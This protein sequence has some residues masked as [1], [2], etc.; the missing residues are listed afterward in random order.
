MRKTLLLL[1][2][3]TLALL[4]AGGVALAATKQCQVG[5]VCNGTSSADTITGTNSN[6]TINGLAGNDSISARDG[7]DKI[8][9]GPNNDTMDGGASNDTYKFADNWG[10]DRISADSAG[11]DT[12]NFAALTSTVNGG[13]AMNLNSNGSTLCPSTETSCL[14]IGGSFLENVVGT[15]F[16]DFLT[17]NPSKNQITSGDGGSW[18][19]STGNIT[20]NEFMDGQAS[21]DTYKGYTPGG[22]ANGVDLIRDTG[23]STNID[24]LIL[25]K[26]N[27]ADARFGWDAGT[28]GSDNIDELIILLPNNE[29]IFLWT[30]FQGTST[31]VCANASGTGLIETI[32]FADDPNV[33]FAQ[34]KQLLG[35]SA[36]G[37]APTGTTQVAPQPQSFTQPPISNGT[38]GLATTLPPR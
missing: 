24:K 8:N 22:P 5:V 26:F 19:P 23:G 29:L 25:T 17:G 21:A 36:A 32:S 27:L 11:V 16:P 7:S 38:E 28:Q 12:V 9:G 34:V 2:T 14:S 18:D 10:A 33:D 30:Y 13:V 1:T 15:R 4:L 35:C 37:S 20:S 31:D 3:M 6:D